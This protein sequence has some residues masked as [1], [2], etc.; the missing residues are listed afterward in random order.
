MF[1][2]KREV[3]TREVATQGIFAA[4]NMIIMAAGTEE[5]NWQ[6]VHE[7]VR[8]RLEVYQATTI[9]KGMLTILDETSKLFCGS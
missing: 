9:P 5:K 7:F 6:E 3:A 2:T 8:P 1:L 4:M